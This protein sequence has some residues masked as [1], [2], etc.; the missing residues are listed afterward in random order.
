MHVGITDPNDNS[1]EG[2]VKLTPTIGM[3]KESEAHGA[4]VVGGNKDLVMPSCMSNGSIS[5][6]STSSL[7]APQIPVSQ[8]CP[9]GLD[10]AV[11]VSQKVG[12]NDFLASDDGKEL[13]DPIC[14]NSHSSVVVPKHQLITDAITTVH[15]VNDLTKGE[16][17]VKIS[18]VNNITDDFPPSYHYIP[19]NLVFQN[20]YV[21]ISLSHIGNEDCCST[22]MGNCVLSSKPCSC[23]NK[24]GG[25]FAYT[26]EGL[27]KE[28]F[29]EECIAISRNPKNYFYCKDCPLERS[30]ND[31]CLEPCKGHLRR[32]LIKECW[33][34][35]GCGKNC[36]N[37]IVQRGITCNLQ[38]GV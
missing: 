17:R 12:N 6:K 29:L 18:W 3:P 7:A 14:P 19:R 23:A 4:L 11:L 30:K 36:G 33:S 27:L 8:P 26:A 28:E 15:D 16:E 1:Q 32:K 24:S 31:D 34:K 20:A 10:D 21:N 9:S 5:V 35:C 38:V 13:K 2:S 37:R 25:G 22:C